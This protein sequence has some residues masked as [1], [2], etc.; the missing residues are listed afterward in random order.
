MRY[1]ITGRYN[2]IISWVRLIAT[3]RGSQARGC[4]PRAAQPEWPASAARAAR[5]AR[6]AAVTQPEAD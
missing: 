5:L 2:I 4:G 1:N 6:A 3:A